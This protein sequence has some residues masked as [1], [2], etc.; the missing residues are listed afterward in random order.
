MLGTTPFQ[1]SLL[2]DA[3]RISPRDWNYVPLQFS[4]Q[5]FLWLE[6][7]SDKIV[8]VS[9]WKT[10]FLLPPPLAAHICFVISLAISLNPFFIWPDDSSSNATHVV[11]LQNEVFHVEGQRIL[12]FAFSMFD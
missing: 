6:L 9:G 12:Q 8:L 10:C 11:C 1:T 7:S 3:K 4:I 5:T 2:L